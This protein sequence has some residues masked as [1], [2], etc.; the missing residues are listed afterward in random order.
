[1]VGLG[2]QPNPNM[3]LLAD[4]IDSTVV[5][6]AGTLQPVGGSGSFPNSLGATGTDE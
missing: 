2:P 1:M 3:A 4:P 6:I 5:Y